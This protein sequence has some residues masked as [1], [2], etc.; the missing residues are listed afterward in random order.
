MTAP[1]LRTAFRSVLDGL[2]DDSRRSVVDSLLTRAV[3]ST[4]AWKPGRPPAK[5]V[6]EAKS[7]AAAASQVHVADPRDASDHLRRGSRA[8]LAGDHA[9]AR[10][11]FEALLLPIAVGDIDLGQHELV[12]EVLNVDVHSCVSQF[13]TSVYITTPLADRADAVFNAIKHVESIA[14]LANPIQDM[15]NVSAGALPE[16]GLFLPVG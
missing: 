8:F 4:A 13:V 6:D 2:D 3:K 15:E 9:S 10:G 16:L 1:E 7:F 14:S 5:I 12:D 11:V